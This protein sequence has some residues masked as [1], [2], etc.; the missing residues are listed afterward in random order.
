M[1]N[2]RK[3]AHTH[4]QMRLSVGLG[5]SERLETSLFFSVWN[6]HGARK[7]RALF[8]L[9]SLCGNRGLCLWYMTTGLRGGKVFPWSNN[10]NH[11]DNTHTQPK[12]SVLN[13]PPPLPP[14]R[15]WEFLKYSS[16][17]NSPFSGAFETALLECGYSNPIS[18]MVFLRPPE[19]TS[20]RAQLGFISQKTPFCI[21]VKDGFQREEKKRTVFEKPLTAG[22]PYART[23]ENQE[24]NLEMRYTASKSTTMTI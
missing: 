16:A 20:W 24:K 23:C 6:C 13:P 4:T 9:L 18:L 22:N 1:R 2:T 21:F 14:N 17:G 19:F 11:T 15:M 3:N 12:S 8:S 10:K 7:S 5:Y